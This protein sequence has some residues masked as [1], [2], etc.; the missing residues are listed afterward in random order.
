MGASTTM[1][2]YQKLNFLNNLFVSWT[3][4]RCVS[5][6]N[7]T[8]GSNLWNRQILVESVSQIQ[9]RLF[10]RHTSIAFLNN[11]R[12]KHYN[13]WQYNALGSRKLLEILDWRLY[14]KIIAFLHGQSDII[15]FFAKDIGKQLIFLIF[16][17]KCVYSDFT[18]KRANLQLITTRRRPRNYFHST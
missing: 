17:F 7:Q 4:E 2:I 8:K 6:W 15:Q 18:K 10:K 9:K 14:R 16:F 13:V 1:W 11:T 12:T 5:K 3:T